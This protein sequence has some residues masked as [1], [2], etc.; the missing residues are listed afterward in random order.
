[1]PLSRRAFLEIVSGWLGAAT[2]GIESQRII[3]DDYFV[4]A[5]LDAAFIKPS[6][7]IFIPPTALAREAADI[8]IEAS[9]EMSPSVMNISKEPWST[10]PKRFT[11][12][13]NIWCHP[14]PSFDSSVECLERFEQSQSF[15]PNYHL[16]SSGEICTLKDGT[17]IGSTSEFIFT[18]V[19]LDRPTPVRCR[20]VVVE[21]PRNY[22]QI[23]LCDSPAFDHD[24]STRFAEFL[25]SLRYVSSP[26]TA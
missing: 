18:T 14:R 21:Q 15:Y 13:I 24:E 20:F 3:R 19:D 2:I 6:G 10:N 12:G 17:A 1:M 23:S 8:G 7:W 22:L 26:P 9:M 25:S 5:D 4:A 11:P 16:T